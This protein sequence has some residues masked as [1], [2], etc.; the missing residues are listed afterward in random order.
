MAGTGLARGITAMHESR[1]ML[2]RY[3]VRHVTTYRYA[4]PVGFSEHRVVFRPRAGPEL[5]VLEASLEV[6]V[7]SQTR[8]IQD[9][10]SN[11]VAVVSLLDRSDL[12]RF[13]CRFVIEHSGAPN[14]ELPLEPRGETLPVQYTDDERD[15]LSGYLR[16]HDDDPDGAVAAWAR[17]F[18]SDAGDSTRAV[19][20][21]MMASFRDEF[22]YRTREA[23]GTQHAAE[24]LRTRAGTCRD[25]AQLMIEAVR[26][27]GIGAR[28]VSGYLYDPALDDAD[29]QARGTQRLRGTESTHAWVHVYLPGAGWVPY[30]PTNSLTG[31]SH[32]I[33]V[34]HARYP[35]QAAP[36]TGSFYGK[37]EDYLGMDVDIQVRRLRA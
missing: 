22:A 2:E 23:E 19:L 15:V 17:G 31:G 9:V 35:D 18:A 36:L 25:Y 16:P 7:R 1:P 5:L 3:E 32:L 30:D 29:P 28:F 4:R 33:R 21:R 13:D 12:L 26:C 24:T 14:L 37:P 8:W 10:F 34:A 20:D 27:L 11:S 6:N